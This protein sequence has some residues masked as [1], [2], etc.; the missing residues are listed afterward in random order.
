MSTFRFKRFDVVNEQ[1]SMKVNTDGVLLGAVTDIGGSE[2]N[3]LDVGTGT[4]TIALMLA[5]RLSDCGSADFHVT[6]I[7]IDGPSAMEA[8]ANFSASPW[9]ERISARQVPLQQYGSAESFDLIVSNPPYFDNSLQAAGE[10]RNA[11][12]HTEVDAG[13]GDSLSYR[14]LIIFAEKHLSAS[15]RLAV[16]LPS[17]QE[18]ALL[19][20]ARSYSLHPVRIT[21]IRTTPRKQPSRIIVQFGRGLQESTEDMVTI[22]DGGSYT[23]QYLSITHDFYL[24]S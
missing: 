19:R 8:S 7:D 14:E 3:I 4:G 23:E 6:G 10:R 9:A 17:D 24:F 20:F 21:R 16:I 13:E 11:A 1:S 15:G 12:R 2:K 5:Q 22:Q 18:K